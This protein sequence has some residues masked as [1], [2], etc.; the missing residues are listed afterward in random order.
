MDRRQLNSLAALGF[1][2]NLLP[3]LPRAHAFGL[4]DLS[5]TE[6]NQGLRTALER[7]ALSAVGLLGRPGGFLDNPKVRI[8]LPGFLEDAAKLLKAVGQKKRVE[9]LEVAMNRAAEAA[10]PLAKDLLANA[11]KTLTVSDAKNILTGGPTSVTS[12]FADR[13]REPL[14]ARFLPVVTDATKKVALADKYNRVASKVPGG[15]IRKGD[16][17]I[18]HY[19]TRKSLDGLYFM[20][21]EEEKNIRQDPVA[22]GNALLT[23]VFGALR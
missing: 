20:I 23:K 6:A 19:V 8:P 7:G 5:S 4:A 17:T 13:T 16:A 14:F 3:L 18:E 9:E 15:L 22:T 10:V 2:L 12:F 21:G 1:G 11:V